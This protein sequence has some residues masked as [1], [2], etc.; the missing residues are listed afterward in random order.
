MAAVPLT[1][2]L[3]KAELQTDP[4][5]LGY[6]PS[7]DSRD[8]N[9]LADAL[10]AIR[11]GGAYQVA[12][13]PVRPDEIFAQ[14]DSTD[15]SVLTTTQL[16]QL[17]VIMGLPHIDLRLANIRTMLAGM[18]LAGSTTRAN[19]AAFQTRNGS[20]AEMLWGPGTVVTTNMVDQALHS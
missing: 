11:S 8:E 14:I 7:I 1:M 5:G 9:A 16:T 13:D 12:R 15:F 3:L 4:A 2:A 20:R 10:N 18:F 17:H 6:A 19:F